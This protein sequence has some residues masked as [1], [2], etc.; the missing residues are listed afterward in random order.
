M[1]STTKLLDGFGGL[2]KKNNVTVDMVI[3]DGQTRVIEALTA[4][5][6][7]KQYNYIK[8]LVKN[9]NARLYDK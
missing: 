9:V 2:D 3:S 4:R 1:S 8:T 6:Q 7:K 5:K